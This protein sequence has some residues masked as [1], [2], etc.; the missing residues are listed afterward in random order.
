MFLVT[1]VRSRSQYMELPGEPK[2]S[3]DGGSVKKIT[4]ISWG[5]CVR[6]LP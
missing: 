4:G 1:R 6:F 3:K 2:T 5:F